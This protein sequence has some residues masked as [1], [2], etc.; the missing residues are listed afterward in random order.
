MRP[1]VFLFSPLIY[2]SQNLTSKR[3]PKNLSTHLHYTLAYTLVYTIV[4]T[5]VDNLFSND[6]T[7]TDDTVLTHP[8]VRNQRL[9]ESN[10]LKTLH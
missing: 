6:I 10:E 5:L 7:V 1:L 9:R 4:Y 3:Y 8:A 2:R